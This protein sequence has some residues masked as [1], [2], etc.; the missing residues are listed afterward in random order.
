MVSPLCHFD[1]RIDE[2][3]LQKRILSEFNFFDQTYFDNVKLDHWSEAK[4]AEITLYITGH[5]VEGGIKT[6]KQD[7][8]FYKSIIEMIAKSS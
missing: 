1:C 4:V 7:K 6:R 3:E 8:I 2:N 5:G